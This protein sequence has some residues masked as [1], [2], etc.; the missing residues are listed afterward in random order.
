[1]KDAH[2]PKIDTIVFDIGNVLIPWEPKWL[3]REFLEDD[4][5]IEHFIEDSDFH[6][7]NALQDAGRPFAEGVAAHRAE[8][9]H[10]HHLIQAYARR[11]EETLGEPNYGMVELI[12]HFK[13][14]GYRVLA[15]TNWSDETFP[16]ACEIYPFLREFE[17]VVVSGQ[18]KLLKPQR[19]I[20][21]LLCQRYVVEP[22]HAVFIDDS[23]RNVEAARDFGL[24]AVQ[25]TG[26][27]N[28]RQAL[29]ALGLPLPT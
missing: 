7:W 25:Y 16:R 27:T 4:A 18:E 6:A 3:F 12:T 2:P 10:Y 8:F 15:L 1:M 29:G 14:H 22:K 28:T 5:A 20:Y 24:H 11:W 26:V 23:A 17:G 19:E 13:R 21:E 9:P